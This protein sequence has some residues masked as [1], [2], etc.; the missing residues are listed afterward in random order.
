MAFTEDLGEFFDTDDF[1][2]TATW[3]P[4]GDVSTTITGIFDNQFV[5]GVGDGEVE[6]E[7]QRPT[8]LVPTADITDMAQGDRIIISGT[9]Y[10][11]AGIQPDDP[12]TSLIILEELDLNED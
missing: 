10:R 3:R 1:A 5:D 8:F 9:Y 2:I 7:D 4:D 6:I 12:G 11:V